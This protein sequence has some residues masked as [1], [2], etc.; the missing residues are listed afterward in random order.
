MF[1]SKTER[2]F[3]TVCCFDFKICICVYEI[4]YLSEEYLLVCTS[5]Q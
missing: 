5:V 3:V 1:L 2:I 4:V